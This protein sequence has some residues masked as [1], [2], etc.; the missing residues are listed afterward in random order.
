MY[1]LL[2]DGDFI[3]IKRN[4]PLF[5]I[6]D[7]K[8][9]DI[10]RGAIYIFQ[11]NDTDSLNNDFKKLDNSNLIKRC[12]A[13]PGDEIRFKENTLYINNSLY[14]TYSIDSSY[15]EALN[16][17]NKFENCDM[18][19]YDKVLYKNIRLNVCALHLT[20]CEKSY[21]FIGDNFYFSI[22]SRHFGPIPESAIIGEAKYVLFSW[23]KNNR[24]FFNPVF[25][26]IK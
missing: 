20:I 23:S 11:Q 2:R 18:F 15:Y 22:D 3:I 14:K 9:V 25:K 26:K 1:P 12:I 7:I 13:I 10:K 8:R 19:L 24:F 16:I 17:F 6:M 5:N 4:K 21:Y